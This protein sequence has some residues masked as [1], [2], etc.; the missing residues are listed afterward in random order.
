MTQHGVSGCHGSTGQGSVGVAP[1]TTP[2]SDAAV[3]CGQLVPPSLRWSQRI[4][5]PPPIRAAA[6]QAHADAVGPNKAQDAGGHAALP[7][8]AMAS[9]MRA[10]SDSR[11]STLPL[12]R[13]HLRGL[14]VALRHRLSGLM[15]R[16]AQNRSTSDRNSRWC[17]MPC[18]VPMGTSQVKRQIYRKETC[19]EAL[20]SLTMCRTAR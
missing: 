15:P 4:A 8:S 11:A 18:I 3:I 16:S 1:G 19:R 20:F 12:R 13:P 14:P 6:G 17:F 7:C 5:S 10:M 2:A 9:R